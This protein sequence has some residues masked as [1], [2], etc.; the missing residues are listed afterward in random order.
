MVMCARVFFNHLI[1][2]QKIR[3]R[4]TLIMPTNC[5]LWMLFSARLHFHFPFP[6][7]C[8]KG[9]QPCCDMQLALELVKVDHRS[10]NWMNNASAAG[11]Q[12]APWLHV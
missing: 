12:A 2:W 7:P 4:L 8:F 11:S 9:C 10:E 3:R 6:F 5:C 1:V